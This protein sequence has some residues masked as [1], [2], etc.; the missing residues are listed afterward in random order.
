ML[1]AL[2]M[3][4]HHVL[5]HRMVST[6]SSLGLMTR[7]RPKRR[8][9]LLASIM[10]LG[11]C[12][13]GAAESVSGPSVIA[14]PVTAEMKSLAQAP[15]MQAIQLRAVARK[16][17]PGFVGS[18]TPPPAVTVAAAPAPM[19]ATSLTPYWTMPFVSFL[20]LDDNNTTIPP[21]TNGAV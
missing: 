16:R 15:V 5:E 21:D 18:A 12:A 4:S 10:L 14:V 19:A 9:A 11:L 8:F 3:W 7:M 6:A 20:G 17:I 2:G 1:R 13:R